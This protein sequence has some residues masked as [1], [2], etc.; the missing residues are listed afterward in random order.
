MF[1][2]GCFSASIEVIRFSGSTTIRFPRKSTISG[3]VGLSMYCYN[4]SHKQKLSSMSIYESGSN[5]RLPVLIKYMT[6]PSDHESILKSVYCWLRVSGADHSL[7]PV[8]KRIRGFSGVISNATFRSMTF[9]LMGSISLPLLWLLA[10]FA[11]RGV[12]AYY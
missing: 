4:L 1:S 10:S 12:I 8:P 3:K 9:I 5:G 11:I 7:R 6:Q 2:H